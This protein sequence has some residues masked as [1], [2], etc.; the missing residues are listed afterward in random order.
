MRR[1]MISDCALAR[2]S[3]R[4]RSTSTTSRR[5]LGIWQSVEEVVRESL[6]RAKIMRHALGQAAER[7]YL[8]SP[9]RK[10]WGS[11]AFVR[12]PRSGDTE[13]VPLERGAA[14]PRLRQYRDSVPSAYA[15]GYRDAAAP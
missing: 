11:E 10:R 8:V 4:P 1:A 15:L 12:Q 2:E 5:C 7:R 6:S 3:T 13:V 9:A 14:A